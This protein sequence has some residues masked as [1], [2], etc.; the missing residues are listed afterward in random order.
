M[1]PTERSL[2]DTGGG[3]NLEGA[4]LP[5]IHSPT[6]PTSCLPFPLMAP[7]GL[8]FN[9]AATFTLSVEF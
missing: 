8:Y 1:G 3:Y 5:H 9:Q 6:F 4:G 2:T 7:P